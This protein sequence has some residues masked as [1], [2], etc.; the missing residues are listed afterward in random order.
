MSPQRLVEDAHGAGLGID[1]L[2]AAAGIVGGRADRA[3]QARL[4]VPVEA[5]VVADIERAVRPDAP[6]RSGRR[7]ASAITAPC[8]PAARA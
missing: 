4:L 8:R 3:Q 1:P 6:G 2:D 5:A 7:R